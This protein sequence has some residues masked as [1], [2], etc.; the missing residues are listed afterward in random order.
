MSLTSYLSESMKKYIDRPAITDHDGARTLTYGELDALSGRAASKLLDLGIREGDCVAINMGRRMEYVAAELA[1]L[2]IGAIVVPL[3]PDYPRNRV[4]Y[5]KKDAGI[6][7]VVEEDFFREL[8]E[9]AA[10]APWRDFPEDKKDFIFYTSGSTGKPKGII[11][12]DR[13]VMAGIIRDKDVV[14]ETLRSLKEGY[15]EGQPFL[16][17]AMATMTFTASMADYLRNFCLGAHVHMLSNEVRADVK[18]LE[19]YYEQAGITVGYI[20][21][22]MLKLY[23]NR[24][25]DLRLVLT[26]GE[27]ASMVYSPDYGILNVLGMTETVCF[28]CAF[29]IDRLYENTP[30]GTPRGDVT[31]RLLDEEGNEVPPGEEGLIVPTGTFPCEYNNMPEE[32]AKTFHVEADGRV[33]IRTGDIGRMLPDGNI[34]YVNRADWMMKIHGQRVEPG[35][36]EDAMKE[37]PGVA[38]AIAKAFEQEDGSMLLCGFYTVSAPV[39]KEQIRASLERS[40]PHYMI[41]SVLAE[42]KSF[43]V[44]ANGKTD[45][46][47]I[48]R[49]D[50]SQQFKDYEEPVGSMEKAL[51]DA[52]GQLLH[53]PRVGRRDDFL[54]LGGNSMNA[55]L[56]A[57]MCKVDGMTPQFI[58]L[59]K[60]P[61]GIAEI[62]S[63]Q[64]QRPRLTKHAEKRE[65]Y[66]VSLAQ[67]YQYDV[68]AHLGKNMNLYDMIVYYELDSDVDTD[69]L[70]RAI[71]ETVQAYPV[72]RSRIN[73]KERWTEIDSS[74]QVRELS[75]SE[76]EFREFRR[77]RLEQEREFTGAPG[78]D[79]PLFE[80]AIVHQGEKCFLFLNLC[81]IIFDGAGVKLFMDTVIA[82]MQGEEGPRES[83][84][85]FDLAV[86]EQD[87]KDTPFYK[88]AWDFYD[89]Y[90]QGMEQ[91]LSF[92]T[93]KTYDNPIL[94]RELLQDVRKEELDL[95]LRRMGISILTLFQGALELTIREL[96][97][98][99][100][101]AYM[102]LYDGRTEAGLENTQG[103]LARAVF[104]RSSIDPD[105]TVKEYLTGIQKSYQNLVYHDVV[106]LPELVHRHPNIRSEI[107]L[108]FRTM[109][110][111]LRLNNKV[112]KINE[113]YW[114]EL[115]NAHRPFTAFDLG[116]NNSPDGL[117]HIAQVSSAGASEE[118]VDRFLTAYD[119]MLWKL[120]KE[121]TVGGILAADQ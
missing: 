63:G 45:R 90:Y 68:C 89:A 52:M 97:H 66:P 51:A 101:F 37:V 120:M 80:A 38:D 43:P 42:M 73:I 6:R 110:E 75:L 114:S 112:L 93:E 78:K 1:V 9:G 33:S 54:E 3:I 113:E 82:R 18:K 64:E 24:D 25:K 2:R 53:I 88:K 48:Q 41:P 94:R 61:A 49:P 58:M 8:E 39:E 20:P 16:F 106:D 29:L 4:D 96:T 5:I 11:F 44:N 32:T 60:S 7:L 50:L 26:A 40:L 74:F 10:P 98:T 92:F 117:T 56:L 103:V 81:H 13:T 71:E 15:Q 12:R 62:F 87:I 119:R 84:S 115:E 107:C 121:E 21:P 31:I 99:A 70:K 105:K 76:Q 55:V 34:L 47:A 28:Y 72:Y 57:E 59:G 46:K 65:R 14:V 67:S 109:P 17:A 100:D 22:R 111:P 104:V 35:E 83:F 95:F 27:K 118:D 30:V 19:D 79:A 36:I 86:H 69:A 91:K 102:N 85:I 77:E 108:N 116:I 23:R